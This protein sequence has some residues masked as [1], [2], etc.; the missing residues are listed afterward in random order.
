MNGRIVQRQA[1]YDAN[2]HQVQLVGKSWSHLG[3][4]SSVDEK[5]GSYDG[6]KLEDIFKL[7]LSKYPNSVPRVIG[8]INPM[9]FDQLQNENG[10]TTWD[11]IE[12]IARPRGA[13]LGTDV[14][15]N[16]LLI[17]DH[18]FPLLGVVK[19]GLN[20]KACECVISHDG[21]FKIYDVT[22]QAAGNDQNTARRRTKSS[23]P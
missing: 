20:I 8:T 23:A 7:V 14:F 13:I 19:E 11:F 5:P 10:E 6:M 12:R 15:G 9:P 18:A 17:G 2:R 21:F 4:Q 16:Y 1:S 3:Y 22:G